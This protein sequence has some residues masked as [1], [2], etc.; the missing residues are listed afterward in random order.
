MPTPTPEPIIGYAVIIGEQA[1][2][3]SLPSDRSVILAVLPGNAAV[4]VLGQV[5]DT[6]DGWVWNR[7]EH[8]GREGY[9]RSDQLRMMSS[10]EVAAYFA[11]PTPT[12][13]PTPTPTPVPTPTPT[14]P[15]APVPTPT[16][17][18]CSFAK[19]LCP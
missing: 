9:L 15:P 6:D 19:S 17:L 5:Y 12:P 16:R 1:N 10:A 2:F 13:V 3:H 8:E 18:C 7:I 11:T 14:L 4:Q